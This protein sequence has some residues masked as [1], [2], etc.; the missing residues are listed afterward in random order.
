MTK[1]SWALVPVGALLLAG[2]GVQHP[3]HPPAARKPHVAT[4]PKVIA[5]PKAK[6]RPRRTHTVKPTPAPKPKTK[7]KAQTTTTLP[8]KVGSSTTTTTTEGGTT[9][10]TKTIIVGQKTTSILQST[11]SD[12]LPTANYTLGSSYASSGSSAQS[13]F[14]ALWASRHETPPALPVPIESAAIPWLS[15]TT[16]AVV[17]EGIPDPANAGT[18]L[19]FG[20]STTPNHWTW[21]PSDTANPPNPKL[22]VPFK[23]E[24]QWADDLALNVPWSGGFL[25]GSDP[26]NSIT[27]QVQLPVGWNFTIFDGTM[28]LFTWDPSTHY[29]PLYY[30]PWSIWSNANAKTGAQALNQISASAKSL[31]KTVF[32]AQP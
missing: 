22:P 16:W 24:L 23:E 12:A 7:S 15:S 25:A 8:P 3:A 19:W 9:T 11:T 14:N 6:A 32:V 26:W 18:V 10:I 1:Q 13:S 21:I 31:A 4:R 28:N 29:S 5:H 27:G 2:C 20:E 17:P 30:A